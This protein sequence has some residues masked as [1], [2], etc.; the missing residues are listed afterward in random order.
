MRSRNRSSAILRLARINRFR[1]GRFSFLDRISG[2]LGG[3][4][5]GEFV[6]QEAVHATLHCYDGSHWTFP[7]PKPG[8]S[9]D[10]DQPHVRLLVDDEPCAN[11][12][13]MWTS[14]YDRGTTVIESVLVPRAF[15]GSTVTAVYTVVRKR[16]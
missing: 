5:Y 4:Q 11:D 10:P 16:E 7:D 9:S 12:Q 1:S 6:V 8:Y 2:L 15:P 3:Y 14:G 13:C